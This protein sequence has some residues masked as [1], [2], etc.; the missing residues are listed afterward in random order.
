MRHG[1]C[2]PSPICAALPRLEWLRPPTRREALHRW[3]DE[4]SRDPIAWSG[5]LRWQLR[6]RDTRIS[7]E[8]FAAIADGAGARILHPLLEPRFVGAL[9]RHGGRLGFGDRR[10]TIAALFGDVVPPVVLTRRDKATFGEVFWGAPTRALMRSW[11]GEGLD[12]EIVD[13]AALKRLW[14]GDGPFAR[15][16][17]LVHQIWLARA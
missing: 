9:A 8:T 2:A 4:R 3:A 15:T 13:P 5:H 7:A 10:A 1:A 17:L 16:A 6:R 11:D 14:S 12:R